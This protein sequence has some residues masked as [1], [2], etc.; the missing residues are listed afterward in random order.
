MK[1]HFFKFKKDLG[2]KKKY[3]LGVTCL[4]LVL[5]SFGYFGYRYY[6]LSKY[7]DG[8][9]ENI[10]FLRSSLK[11]TE[12]EKEN[13][14]QQLTA[15]RTQV[16]VLAE[17]VNKITGTVG[18]L[19]KL[20]KI[21]KELLQK[22]SKIYFLNEHYVPSELSQIDEQY[23]DN[24]KKDQ[25]MHAKVL[26]KLISLLDS[27]RKNGIDIEVLSAYRSFETQTD[28][29]SS[30]NM[31][32]GKNTANQFSADQGYSE[33]QLGTTVDFT[34]S[35]IG[36]TLRAFDKSDAYKWLT[37]NAHRFGFVISY[38]KSNKYYKYEPWHWR[39]VGSGLAQWLYD[40]DTNFYA[41]DQR[42]IDNYL[43]SLFD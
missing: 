22:Y 28:L 7:A 16:G 32:Y 15:E 21:D 29:K 10:S 6:S 33:H 9:S 26:P 8:L 43:V 12:D 20:S 11:K 1:I 19:N 42:K 30:Y 36:S 4:I 35:K 2:I 17:Q 39:F 34:T 13:L 23:L 24:K 27:A 38:P 31:V 5:V 18:E 41:I 14:S 37:N 25:W 40:N 3:L